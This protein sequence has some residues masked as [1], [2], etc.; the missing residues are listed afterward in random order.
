MQSGRTRLQDRAAASI[1]VTGQG[2]ASPGAS[3][4]FGRGNFEAMPFLET[5]SFDAAAAPG[6]ADALTRLQEDVLQ[7]IVIRNVLT[8]DECRAISAEL[9]E[10]RHSF[11]TTSFPAPFRSHF[12]G[13]NLN[14]ADPDLRAYF[15][16]A[17]GFTRSLE[18][19][20]LSRGGFESRILALLSRL[21]GGRPYGPPSLPDGRS[22]MV[23]T[24]RSHHEGGFI[25]P[26]FDNEQRSRPSY[27]HLDTLVAGDIFSFVLT[28]SKAEGG[29]MLEVFDARADAWS[30]RFQNRDR[31]QEKPDLARFARHAFDVEAGTV[32][33]LRSGRYLHQVTPVV[34][35]CLRWTACSFMARARGGDGVYCWG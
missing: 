10:N 8:P 3:P 6:H 26:H 32:V 15:E 17:P 1:I 9:A 28:L 16:M 31:A 25:P 4:G 20:M 11:P 35:S 27:R 14:L 29:G 21:D 22:Y 33:V 7:A 30:G 24:L 34:G 5:L 13:M 12:Y 23:T 18:D 19:L 2:Q